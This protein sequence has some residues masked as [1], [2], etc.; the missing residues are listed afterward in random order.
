M[1]S[2][3]A[4]VVLPGNNLA[5]TQLLWRVSTEVCHHLLDLVSTSLTWANHVYCK[6]L[7][8]AILCID[9]HQEIVES[10]ALILSPGS[11]LT[12]QADRCRS[13]LITY[14]IVWQEAE[15]LL[16]TTD[17]L[18]LAL[19]DSNLACNP[20]ETC[21]AVAQL[22]VILLGN[23]SNHL[24]CNDG[25]YEEVCW[26]Q[27]TQ[28]LLVLD[29]IVAEHHGCLVTVDDHPLALV[30]AANDSQAVSIRVSSYYEVSVQLGTELH[31]ESHSLSILWVRRNHCR[32]VAIYNHLLR[33]Y[34]DVLEAPRTQAERYDD[35]TCTMHS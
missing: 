34:I 20:L 32:E 3:Q 17:V 9:L 35:T 28:L 14:L 15:A 21:V 10:L 24:C 23:L 26:L 5:A 30:I 33:N 8:E 11:N 22:Y 2:L 16:T 18:L 25:L 27:L 6:L 1:L 13:I 7:T 29:D 31:T 4:L 19:R 12:N